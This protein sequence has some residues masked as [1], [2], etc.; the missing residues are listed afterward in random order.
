M[1]GVNVDLPTVKDSG[2]VVILLNLASSPG[3]PIFSMLHKKRGGAG[4]TYH[5]HDVR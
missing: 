4:K 1:P 3:S 5:V 2:E